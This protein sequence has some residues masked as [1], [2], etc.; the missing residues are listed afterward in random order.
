MTVGELLTSFPWVAPTEVWTHCG[1]DEKGE[2][3]YDVS[4]N[5]L[6]LGT[7]PELPNEIARLEIHSCAVMNDGDDGLPTFQIYTK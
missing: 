6:L 3:G 4:W 2:T 7:D 5:R 1:V